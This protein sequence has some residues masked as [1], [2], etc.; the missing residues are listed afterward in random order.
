M[1]D[2]QMEDIYDR[3]IKDEMKH[4][5]AVYDKHSDKPKSK[6][7]Q[8]ISKYATND[9]LNKVYKV[10]QT[11]S[12]Y[13]PFQKQREALGSYTG[14]KVGQTVGGIL[15][16]GIGL[17]AGDRKKGAKVGSRFGQS[18]LGFKKGGRV[19]KSGKYLVHKQE[20]IVPKKTPVTKKQLSKVS[21]RNKL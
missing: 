15:G 19:K 13:I 5:N 17:L 16:G 7:N 3:N 20:F 9:G 12:S 14:G 8:F 6:L 2:I 1:F 11:V 4:M 21:K 10:G 18:V